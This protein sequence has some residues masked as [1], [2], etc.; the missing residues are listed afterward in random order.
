MIFLAACCAVF[1]LVPG[2]QPIETGWL[3]CLAIGSG[4]SFFREMRE[5]TLTHV[6]AKIARYSY[7]MYL[8]HYFAIWVG[9]VV[10]RNAGMML[11]AAIFVAVLGCLSVGMYHAVEAPLIAVGA[12]IAQK[13]MSHEYTFRMKSRSAE[14]TV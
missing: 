5:S 4:V 8:F 1:L 7:G 9:F 6:T 2:K 11:Q 10:F 12:R 3:I 13:F 14:G